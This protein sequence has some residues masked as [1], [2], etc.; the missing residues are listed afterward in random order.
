M[1]KVSGKWLRWNDEVSSESTEATPFHHLLE[2]LVIDH[3]ISINVHLHD[4]LL[5]ILHRSPLL[6]PQRGQNG[7]QLFHGDEAIAVLVEDVEGLSHVLVL[8]TVVHDVL[9][10]FPELIDVDTPISVNVYSLDHQG[11]LL[12]GN[13]NAQILQGVV[14]L[15]L[16]DSPVTVAVEHLEDALE[17]V[18]VHWW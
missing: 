17:L 16:R 11:K 13:E 3:S 6:Q 9:V 18:G 12:V 10:E 14:E 1:Y 15:L 5:A 2:L 8:V 4:H 7:P